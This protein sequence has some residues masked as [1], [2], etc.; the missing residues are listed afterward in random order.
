M[1]PLPLTS[2][3]RLERALTRLRRWTASEHLPQHRLQGTDK[4]GMTFFSGSF[5]VPDD[6]SHPMD[7]FLRLDGWNKV[8]LQLR[9]HLHRKWEK[10]AYEGATNCIY[11]TFTF[12]LLY[13]KRK[14]MLFRVWLGSM[15]SAWGVTGLRWGLR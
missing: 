13:M 11:D 2:T 5:Q 14:I 7:T 6:S 1:A 15:T 10:D 12:S 8:R 3:S 9:D 4:G